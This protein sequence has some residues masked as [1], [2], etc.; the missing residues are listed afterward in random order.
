VTSPYRP[1][2]EV[3]T[4]VRFWMQI[5]RD[6]RRTII[7]P[8]E[9]VERVIAKVREHDLQDH[10]SVMPSIVCPPNSILVVDEQALKADLQRI[11]RI[12]L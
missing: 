2:S 4:N 8:P 11:R 12:T 3:E 9:L 7:C 6:S 5:I 1:Y 10:L